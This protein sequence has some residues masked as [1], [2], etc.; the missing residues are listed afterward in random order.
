[1]N[2]LE[3]VKIESKRLILQP[4][5]LHFKQDIFQEFTNEITVFM[6]AKS[7]E[8]I[9]ETEDF[10]AK[11]IQRRHT[12]NDLILTILSKADRE[13]LGNCGIHYINT[14]T[15]ELG[16]WLKKSAHGNGFGKEAICALKNWCDRHLNYQYLRYPVDRKNIPSRKIPESL[17]GQIYLC[18][19]QNYKNIKT[20]DILEYRI[21]S[22][23]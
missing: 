14:P 11:S 2:D 9:Q 18:Y 19:Q 16:I 8:S 21:F 13:F 12:K 6:L 7:P 20:L 15:P 3:A 17:G 5:E 10:I 1:M 23:N 4:I 22:N